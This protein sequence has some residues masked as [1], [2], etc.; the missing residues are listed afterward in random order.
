MKKL[1]LILFSVPWF[2]AGAQDLL[3]GKMY[4]ANSEPSIVLYDRTQLPV[5]KEVYHTIYKIYNANKKPMCQVTVK[6]DRLARQFYITVRPENAA[7]F[8]STTKYD[9]N[10]SGLIFSNEAKP[11]TGFSMQNHYAFLFSCAD[12]T[13]DYMVLHKF[14]LNENQELEL[15]PLSKNR[16]KKHNEMMLRHLEQHPYL[17]KIMMGKEEEFY[18]QLLQLRDTMRAKEQKYRN[19]VNAINTDLHKQATEKFGKKLSSNKGELYDGDKRKGK[20]D[21]KGILV[22]NGNIYSGVFSEGK[23]IKGTAK[24]KSSEFEY[25]G[26]YSNDTFNGTGLI[27]FRNGNYYLGNLLNGTVADGIGFLKTDT[28]ETFYGT[29]TN[30]ERSGYAQIEL[31]NADK[32]AGEYSKGKLVKGYTKETDEYSNTDYYKTEDGKETDMKPLAAEKYL[33]SL[34]GAAGAKQ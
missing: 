9:P 34:L 8:G 22:S 28:G 21:G 13:L 10:I 29:I 15:D 24:I 6:N 7:S 32:S 23:L 19:T 1:L 17:R 20:P 18:Q 27:S 16:I 26:C 25:T 14:I 12:S 5:V 30:G 2:G 3:K 31:S 33:G 11:D 4:N